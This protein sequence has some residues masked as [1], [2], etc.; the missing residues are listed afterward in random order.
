VNVSLVG[1]TYG[2]SRLYCSAAVRRVF[3]A[4]VEFAGRHRALQGPSGIKP[5]PECDAVYAE[6]LCPRRQRFT[7]AVEL[8]DPIE[9]CVP[10]LLFLR[11]P[12]AVGPAVRTVV[13]D[14]VEAHARGREAHV[15]D[16]PGE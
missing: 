2:D 1:V 5:S 3:A 12:P 16:K 9:P 6:L 4:S 14:S 15:G 13:V 7:L 11:R 10:I 8:D